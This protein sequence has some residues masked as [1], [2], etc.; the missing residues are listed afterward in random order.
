MWFVLYQSDHYCPPQLSCLQE[1]G[2]ETGDI[3]VVLDEQEHP[4]FKR[5]GSDL[6]MELVSAMSSQVSISVQYELELSA[7]TLWHLYFFSDCLAGSCIDT[8]KWNLL[9]FWLSA[10]VITVWWQLKHSVKTSD[11]SLYRELCSIG[12]IHLLTHCTVDD[13]TQQIGIDCLCVCNNYGTPLWASLWARQHIQQLCAIPQ[14]IDLSEALC[15]FHKVI[16]TLDK[17]KLVITSHP[18]DVIKHGAFPTC[19]QHD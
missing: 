16:T 9:T 1:P 2:Y 19:K 6:F 10:S 7:I 3:V 17:R 8:C 13:F 11:S 14:E 4:V 18:G 5:K 12:I 15:G